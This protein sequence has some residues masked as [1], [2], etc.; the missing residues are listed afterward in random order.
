MKKGMLIIC[1]LASIGAFGQTQSVFT[2]E[3]GY[4]GFVKIGFNGGVRHKFIGVYTGA[5]F[6][7]PAKQKQTFISPT[8]G[9]ELMPAKEAR[10]NP[11][12]GARS[13]FAFPVE[14]GFTDFGY[15]VYSGARIKGFSLAVYFEK[16]QYLSNGQMG[17]RL[18]YTNAKSINKRQ[19]FNKSTR[20]D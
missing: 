2:S 5:I 18:I 13:L 6:Y 17:I 9:F 11:F 10:F 8:V 16:M 7:A 4:D 14:R 3:F 15:Q 19:S 20:R 12:L 1:I